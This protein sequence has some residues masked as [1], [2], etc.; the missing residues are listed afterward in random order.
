M[1]RLRV[2]G[3]LSLA[4]L[5]AVSA[6]AEVVMVPMHDGTKLAT[7]YLLPNGGGTS[8][9]IL[10]RSPYGRPRAVPF[11][12]LF[13]DSGFAFV[14]QDTR[15]RGDSEGRDMVFAD[16]GW[17]AHKDGADTV[18]WLRAQPWCNGKV[19]TW[20]YSALGITQ[21][22]MAP[23]TDKLT[24]QSMATTP[25]SFYGQV[26]YEGGVL[27][28]ELIETWLGWQK[29]LHV[30][31]IYKSHTTYDDFWALHNVGDQAAKIT[32]PAV[33]ISG[34]FDAF[35]QGTV[36]NFVSRQNRGGVGARGNQKLIMGPW[37]HA[38]PSRKAGEL[39]FPEN[40]KF[41]I[42]TYQIRFFRHWLLGENN[43]I[44]GEP[45]VH[46]YAMGDV[47][48]PGAPGNEW[49][50]ADAWPPFE[51]KDTPYY[52]QAEGGLALDKP[53][54]DASRTFTYDPANPC[55]TRGGDC[56]TV[57]PGPMDQRDVS[58]RADVL[59]FES[60][61]LDAPLEVTGRINA[62]LYVSTDAPDTDFTAKLVD[63]YPDGR[64]ILIQDGIRRL[65]FR[66]GYQGAE[67]LPAGKVAGLDI[68][69]WTTSIIF[70]K[71]HKIGVQVSS[72]NYPRFEKNPNS[73]DD[74]PSE[75]NLH[76]AHNTVHISSEYP[77]A[78]ILP[79][80]P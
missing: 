71:G 57:P 5:A 54:K 35:G 64:E 14:V 34:W 47:A 73:G 28:K 69:L 25:C 76:V 40:A 21:N 30:L 53:P 32:S 63:I 11:A 6:R 80:R 52:L 10:L 23:A 42:N 72:S 77:S 39:E 55:P 70:N 46:Y 66:N 31:D 2:V 38:G 7:E 58:G 59:K 60:S 67:P 79:V 8:P 24:C 74:F 3:L 4:V 27:R 18:D 43:G 48:E 17:G 19:G 12:K 15:G 37:T 68:D 44:M 33:H 9:V 29:S 51:A 65:K 26:A 13:N 49:R 50:T 1:R 36:D 22:M 16:D 78:V 20:C 41:D 45:A 62:K 75:S 56:L 61:V